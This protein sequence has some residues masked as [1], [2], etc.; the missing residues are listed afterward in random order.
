MSLPMLHHDAGSGLSVSDEE[1][2]DMSGMLSMKGRAMH[3]ASPT[4][5]DDIDALCNDILNSL[6]DDD[7]N[8]DVLAGAH[9]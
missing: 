7:E 3:P 8:P 9:C 6:A 2:D 1:S 4:F 5:S